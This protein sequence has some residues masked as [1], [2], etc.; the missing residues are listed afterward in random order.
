MHECEG[1]YDKMWSQPRQYCDGDYCSFM[2]KAS[3]KCLDVFGDQASSGSNVL[4]YRSDGVP[5]QSFKW[6]SGNWVTPTADWDMVGYNQNDKVTHQISNKSWL[7]LSERRFH[8][9]DRQMFKVLHGLASMRL[10]N[11]FRNSCPARQNLSS[12]EVGP[13]LPSSKTE[14]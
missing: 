4:T 9:K 8:I 13:S 1:T 7:E 6:V 11:I 12:K 5:D 14:L 10:S 2:N 3:G